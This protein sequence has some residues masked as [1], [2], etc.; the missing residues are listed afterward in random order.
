MPKFKFRFDSV[1]D[2]KKILEKKIQKEIFL[3]EKE[4]NDYKQKRQIILDE[5]E[6]TRREMSGLSR[7]SAYQS[8][9]IYDAQLEK[10]IQNLEK[11]IVLLYEKKNEKT[12]ELVEKK[13]EHKIL[14]VLKENQQQN[15][16]EEEK[17]IE[18]KELN[19]IAIRNFNGNQQ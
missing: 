10:M 4:I 13:K 1:M 5:K 11:K 15:F 16:L 3:I 14:E 12:K 17:K 18:L 7:V 2:V 19:E 8:A 9:K 6:K